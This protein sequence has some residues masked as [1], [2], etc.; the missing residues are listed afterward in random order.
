MRN[1][2]PLPWRSK[3]RIAARLQRSAPP[4]LVVATAQWRGRRRGQARGAGLRGVAVGRGVRGC[5]V[6]GLL[7]HSPERSVSG[8]CSV[9]L[10]RLPLAAALLI[11]RSTLPSDVLAAS[12]SLSTS[13]GTHTSHSTVWMAAGSHSVSRSSSARARLRD[14]RVRPAGAG[15][16]RMGGQNA[17]KM[18]GWGQQPSPALMWSC[19]R[20]GRWGGTVDGNWRAGTFQ[21]KCQIYDWNLQD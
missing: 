7:G 3:R 15:T 19:F 21:L 8:V 11:H 2:W 17:K 14:C 16:R 4:R 18:P 5:A 9:M 13:A 10:L 20:N 12:D 1:S 6:C